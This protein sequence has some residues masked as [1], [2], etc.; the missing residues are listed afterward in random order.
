MVLYFLSEVVHPPMVIYMGEDKH[1]NEQLIRWS[2]PEDIWFHVDKL[3]SAHVYLRLPKGKTMDDIPDE[4][5]TDCLQLVKANSI[6]GCKLNDVQIVYTPSTN[7][8]K[9]QGMDVGQVGF[10]DQKLVRTAVVAKKSS[11]IINRLNKTK[12][13]KKPDLREEREQRDKLERME[14]RKKEQEEKQREK[15]AAEKQ[16]A[17]AD[18]RSY[19]SIMKE[20]KMKSNKCDEKVDYRAIEE[21][22]M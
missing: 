2:F 17:E 1:E 19:K 15:E 16:K 8:K 5:L 10:H 21:D 3:S 18:L 13:E 14:A 7:L 9:T 6:Q 20:D 4:V 12:E 22:F 11:E